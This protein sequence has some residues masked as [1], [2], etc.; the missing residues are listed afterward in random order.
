MSVF[1]QAR[2]IRTTCTIVVRVFLMRELLRSLPRP[3]KFTQVI[4]TLIS[5]SC[6]CTLEKRVWMVREQRLFFGEDTPC[7]PSK[8]GSQLLVVNFSLNSSW[9]CLRGTRNLLS[10]I[11]LLGS[12]TSL[13]QPCTAT[14]TPCKV[15][16]QL[17]VVNFS[18]NSSW[19]CLRGTRNLLWEIIVLLGSITFIVTTLYCIKWVN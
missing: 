9:S 12:I 16:S 11:L 1:A 4:K 7:T 6:H 3:S 13:W 15:G 10:E 17:L 5:R 14:N 18:L 19:S 2:R 8:V